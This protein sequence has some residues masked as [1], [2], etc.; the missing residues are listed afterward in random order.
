MSEHSSP[1][2][3]ARP[4][5]PETAPPAADPRLPTRG[6]WPAAHRFRGRGRVI[7]MAEHREAEE[8]HEQFQRES[9]ARRAAPRG[10]R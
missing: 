7:S 1:E 2:T 8:R 6:R 5:A 3:A 10:R 9:D 4:D